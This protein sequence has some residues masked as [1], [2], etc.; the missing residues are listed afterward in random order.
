M[1]LWD[2]VGALVATY[3]WGLRRN[4]SSLMTGAQLFQDLRQR[5]QR[6]LELNDTVLQ[7]LVVARMSLELDEPSRARDAL[8]AS[9]DSA[10]HMITDLLS[11]NRYHTLE[12]TR[13]DSATLSHQSLTD[14]DAEGSARPDEP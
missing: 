4:Y 11:D 13:V 1:S 2:V 12:L 6:A 3:Y 7:G 8:A 14:A 9:I 5:E 10:S